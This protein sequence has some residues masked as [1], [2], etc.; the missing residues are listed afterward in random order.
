M[1]QKPQLVA[2]KNGLIVNKLRKS[3]S[4]KQIVRDVSLKLQR[5]KMKRKY[6]M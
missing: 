6:E 1:I 5:G 4:H 3:L 2:S